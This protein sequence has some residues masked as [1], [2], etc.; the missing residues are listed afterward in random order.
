MAEEN[1][2][3]KIRKYI[4]NLEEVKKKIKETKFPKEFRLSESDLI[5]D[6]DMFFDAHIEIITT[7]KLIRFHRPY[8]N[9]LKKV[10]DSV[11]IEMKIKEIEE[12]GYE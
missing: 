4:S 6:L 8:Y 5:T 11:N 10:L 12:S 2:K 7:N 3:I 9:R 1:K